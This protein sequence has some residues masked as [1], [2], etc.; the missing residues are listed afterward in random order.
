MTTEICSICLENIE[1]DKCQLDCN[2]SLHTNCYNSL[3]KSSN[4]RKC[5]LCRADF[6]IKTMICTLCNC[7]MDC[8]Q[9]KCDVL[10]SE[11]CGCMFHYDCLRKSRT[12]ECVKCDKTL[13]TE[14]FTAISFLHFENAYLKWVGKIQLCRDQ[15]CFKMCNPAR[16]GYCYQHKKQL[17]SNKAIVLTFNYFIRY[18]YETDV[19]RRNEIFYEILSYMN[20]HHV[21]DDIKD[22]NFE[23][24]RRNVNENNILHN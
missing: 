15:T 12:V 7:E 17:S 20:L 5:P 2:H 1:E 11:E 16:F 14:K 10:I 22:V 9:Y 24:V 4:S 21:M 6:K 23:E 19:K 13:S 18:V 8:D 3:I